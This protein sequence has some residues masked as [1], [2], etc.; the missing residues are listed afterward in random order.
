MQKASRTRR[1]LS[2]PRFEAYFTNDCPFQIKSKYCACYSLKSMYF[3]DI[4]FHKCANIKLVGASTK[5]MTISVWYLKITKKI[6]V[7]NL[8]KI[9]TSFMEQ[10]HSLLA[11][12]TSHAIMF[13]CLSWFINGHILWAQRKY[14][15]YYS[16]VTWASWCL[17]SLATWVSAQQFLRTNIK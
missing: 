1:K 11:Q 9:W 12:L 15:F 8:T 4:N 16:D 5:V 6:Y 3:V 13:K 7:Q 14:A 10:T 2:I 17:S